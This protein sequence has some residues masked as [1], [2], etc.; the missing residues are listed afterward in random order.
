MSSPRSVTAQLQPAK[1]PATWQ[2]T[3]QQ[4][5]KKHRP[6]LNDWTRDGFATKRRTEVER[7]DA[8]PKCAQRITRVDAGISQNDFA[9]R[10]ES[11]SEPCLVENVPEREKWP[12][13]T[14]TSIDGRP[15]NRSDLDVFRMKVGEGDDGKTLRV[16]LRDFVNYS[17]FNRDDSPLYVFDQGFC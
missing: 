6:K 15:S 13:R 4:A 14:W 7:L 1:R 2:E 5:K 3:L 17:K 10:F 12:L 8:V 11:R 16:A 9:T